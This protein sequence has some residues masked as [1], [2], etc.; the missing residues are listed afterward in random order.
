MVNLDYGWSHALRIHSSISY[1][2]DIYILIQG[3]IRS[4]WQTSCYREFQLVI[5]F[6]V[7]INHFSHWSSCCCCFTQRIRS[8]KTTF[9]NDRRR[10]FTQW[11]YC[12]GRFPCPFIN[13]WG[14]RSY[15]S[16]CPYLIC[17]T[18]FWRCCSWNC[19]RICYKLV[20]IKDS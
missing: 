8:F 15:I 16:R 20:F 11:R 6:N 3:S 2:D 13:G 18:Q 7:W 9:Y 12:N 5:K 4:T 1:Y 19:R 14:W 17:L 10:E